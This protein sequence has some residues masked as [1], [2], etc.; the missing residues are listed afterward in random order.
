MK[1]KFFAVAAVSAVIALSGG[2]FSRS[3]ETAACIQ[4]TV[5]QVKNDSLYIIVNQPF[6]NTDDLT[7]PEYGIVF[8]LG[9]YVL[10]AEDMNY[11]YYRS[12][13]A[14]MMASYEFSQRRGGS[15]FYGGIAVPKSGDALT[16]QFYT[17]MDDKSKNGKILI[18]KMTGDFNAKRGE[19]WFLSTDTNKTEVNTNNTAK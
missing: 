12:P 10:E 3:S 6:D 17:Y 14:L 16:M 5:S 18:W 13:K 2:C 1:L 7:D 4:T 15:K 11:R 8:S 19:K 9:K